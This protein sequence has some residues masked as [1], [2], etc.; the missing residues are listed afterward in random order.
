MTFFFVQSFSLCTKNANW[1]FVTMKCKFPQVTTEFLAL[2][3]LESLNYLL[4][5]E[6]KDSFFFVSLLHKRTLFW[7]KYKI[8][9]FN[10][11][12]LLSFFVFCFIFSFEKHFTISQK[13]SLFPIEVQFWFPPLS[14][15]YFIYLCMIF[16]LRQ[17]SDETI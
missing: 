8:F 7:K 2:I 17:L 14:F 12:I 13:N 11:K 5:T 9:F 1:F 6:L 3:V 16:F 10:K 15:E 4:L